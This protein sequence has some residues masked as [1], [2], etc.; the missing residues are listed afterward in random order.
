MISFGDGQTYVGTPSSAGH[1]WTTEGTK[2]VSCTAYDVNS[3]PS[4]A[5][6]AQIDVGGPDVGPT[7]TAFT[8]SPAPVHPGIPT[9]FTCSATTPPGRLVAGYELDFGDSTPLVDGPSN[10]AVHVYQATGTYVAVCRAYDASGRSGVLQRVTG[11]YD[12]T[13]SL[14]VTRI[15]SG[16]GVVTSTPAAISCGATCS[17][18]VGGGETITLAA[19]PDA[20]S[21]FAGWSGS[22]C[23]GIDTVHPPDVRRSTRHGNLPPERGDRLLHHRTVPHGRHAGRQRDFRSRPARFAS[24]PW[25][26]AGATCRPRPR[27]PH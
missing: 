9:T 6:V 2:S 27:P 10:Q 17:S 20:G 25:S 23:L 22:G 15:G 12:S 8:V 4:A 14:Q 5:R 26:A 16:S 11:V 21:R 3:L 1:A 13:Y 7:I 19:T 24:S 18:L